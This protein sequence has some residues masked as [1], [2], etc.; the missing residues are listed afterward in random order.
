MQERHQE[1]YI[2]FL[3]QIY[4][5]E[6]TAK[7]KDDLRLRSLSKETRDYI[8]KEIYFYSQDLDVEKTLKAWK[9]VKRYMTS[10]LDNEIKI[11][12]FYKSNPIY[13]SMLY[14]M[15]RRFLELFPIYEDII[16]ER[17]YN[18]NNDKYLYED[19]LFWTNLPNPFFLREPRFIDL[20]KKVMINHDMD[21]HRVGNGIGMIRSWLD[22][23][24]EL[25]QY[26]ETSDEEKKYYITLLEQAIRGNLSVVDSNR[27]IHNHE[28]RQEAYIVDILEKNVSNNQKEWQRLRDYL[29]S[30]EGV[31]HQ[32]DISR[33]SSRV[34][35]NAIETYL[36]YI[37]RDEHFSEKEFLLRSLKKE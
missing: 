23:I 20:N 33:Y 12:N 10:S 6:R 30:L 17:K 31:R 18:P 1:E 14:L 15:N 4:N 13:I 5:F 32:A 7:A 3:K 11:G 24:L 37:P 27:L 35:S 21:F 26:K 9:N 28:F 36:R 25:N 8:K 29:L 2:S 22:N 19:S 16:N 34:E